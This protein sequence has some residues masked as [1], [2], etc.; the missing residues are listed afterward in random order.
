V[1]WAASLK[2][3]VRELVV[4]ARRRLELDVVIKDRSCGKFVPVTVILS[5][6]SKF[7]FVSGVAA[8]I[9]QVTVSAARPATFGT[10][11]YLVTI[12]GT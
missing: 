3:K 11:P 2:V 1:V 5:P 9:V 7:K 4:E 6:P 10:F 12:S 8:V